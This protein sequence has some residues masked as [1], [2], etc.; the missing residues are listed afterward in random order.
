MEHSQT[1]KDDWTTIKNTIL[2]GIGIA[3]IVHLLAAAVHTWGLADRMDAK[4]AAAAAKTDA[5]LMVIQDQITALRVDIKEGRDES[6][7]R[8]EDARKESDKKFENARKESDEKFRQLLQ[9]V[10]DSKVGIEQL[11][12]G[13]R[14][15]P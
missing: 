3:I 12:H 2:G 11:E 8:F 10:L 1:S 7:D 14:Q 9:Q 15:A 5:Q 4:I 6:N 13:A